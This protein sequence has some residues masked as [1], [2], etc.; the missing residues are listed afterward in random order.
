MAEIEDNGCGFAM[1]QKGRPPGSTGLG[2]LGMRER[3]AIAGGSLT[4]ESHPAAARVSAAHPTARSAPRRG[5]QF[6]K[7]VTA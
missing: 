1:N 3:A 7:E 6:L 5:R 4:I 2:L